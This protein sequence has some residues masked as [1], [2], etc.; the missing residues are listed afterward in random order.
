M[1]HAINVRQLSEEDKV[2]LDSDLKSL[3]WTI[4]GTSKGLQS[5]DNLT[6]KLASLWLSCPD[7]HLAK[8]PDGYEVTPTNQDECPKCGL[9][10]SVIIR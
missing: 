8:F 10:T 4:Q 5:P 9:P 7:G 6:D 1:N 3:G 2:K